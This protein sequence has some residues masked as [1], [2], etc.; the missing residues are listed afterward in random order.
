MDSENEE[1]MLPTPPKGTKGLLVG[2]GRR[3]RKRKGTDE[4]TEDM[5][6]VVKQTRNK[7]AIVFERQC[8]CNNQQCSHKNHKNQ[9]QI[10]I[11]THT[12]KHISNFNHKKQY[13]Q[14]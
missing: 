12:H 6:T 14:Q 10:Q 7:R 5:P 11:H 1:F 9:S 8:Q 2:K 13:I 4:V 3:Q